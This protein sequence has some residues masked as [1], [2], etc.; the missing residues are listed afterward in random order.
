M[1][2]KIRARREAKG[3]SMERLGSMARLSKDAIW[4]IETGKTLDPYKLIDIAAALGCSVAELRD[5]VSQ[6]NPMWIGPKGKDWDKYVLALLEP[7][8]IDAIKRAGDDQ[9]AVADVLEQV[10]DRVRGIGNTKLAAK[11]RGKGPDHLK[12]K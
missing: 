4:K 11:P 9:K 10:I 1:G 6:G 5:D 3:L 12:G 2:E 8:D 7:K